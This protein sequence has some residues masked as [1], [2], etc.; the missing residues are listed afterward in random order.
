VILLLFL[1]AILGLNAVILAQTGQR[2]LFVNVLLLLA[3][4]VLLIENL[5]FLERRRDSINSTVVPAPA[6]NPNEGASAH[7][8][9]G[10]RSSH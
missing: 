9:Q 2:I 5:K 8:A 7:A 4:I 6:K 10:T 3:G 1:T